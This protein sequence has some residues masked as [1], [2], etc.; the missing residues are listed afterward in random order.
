MQAERWKQ[1]EGLYQAAL[2]EPLERRAE[3]MRQACSGDPQL[4]AEVES[5]LNAA[6]EESSF[7]EGSPVPS[8]SPTPPEKNETE[9]AS[10][11]HRTG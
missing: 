10:W 8:A 4:R 3:F 5:L 6:G 11:H 7:L 1:I 2:A 9:G